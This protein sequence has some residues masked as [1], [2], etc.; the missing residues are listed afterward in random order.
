M[1]TFSTWSAA[2]APAAVVAAAA[3][4]TAGTFQKLWALEGP[5]F[6]FGCSH[7]DSIEIA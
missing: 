6:C 4:K 5:Q 2:A 7:G 1:S 3:L